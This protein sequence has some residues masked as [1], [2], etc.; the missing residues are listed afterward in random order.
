MTDSPFSPTPETQRRVLLL[1]TPHSYRTAAFVDA[2]NHL[3][4]EAVQAVDMPAELAAHWN[5]RLGVDFTAVEQ[6]SQQLVD[7]LAERPVQAILSLDDS[8]AFLAARTSQL[9]GLPHNAAAAAEAAR[10]KHQ[11][12]QLLSAGGV[13]SPRFRRFFSDDP[14]PTIVPTVETEIGYPCV[15]KPED[16]NGSRGVIRANNRD[17]LLAAAARLVALIGPSRHFLVEEYMPG[18]EVALEGILDGG[19]LQVLALFDKP[20]PLEGPFFEETIYVTPSRLPAAVQDNIA[21]TTAQAARAL[22]LEMGPIHAEL[23]INDAGAWIV[24]L[25]GRSIGGLCSR[26]LHFGTDASLEELILRQATGLPIAGLDR[27]GRAGGVMMIPIPEAGILREVHGVDKAK[28]VPGIEDVQITAQRNYPL[29]PLPEGDAYLGFIFAAGDS[30]EA[31]EAALR[32]AHAELR[33][34]ILPEIRLGVISKQ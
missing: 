1:T 8:G 2:A 25:A 33:F 20:D 4:I 22:G 19:V 27:E 16:L 9:L 29:V 3:G 32:A 14:L 23:R 15:V 10:N 12:R 31:V 21:T 13:L 18:V 5:F 26:T 34:E 7:A 17:E 6:A 24:E 30:P 28:A 11:M